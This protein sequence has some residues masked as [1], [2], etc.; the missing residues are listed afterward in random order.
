MKKEALI[1]CL[2]FLIVLSCPAYSLTVLSG[3]DTDGCY[4]IRVEGI[5]ITYD[6]SIFSDLY[7]SRN[8]GESWQL[9]FRDDKKIVDWLKSGGVRGLFSIDIPAGHYN[10]VRTRSHRI[11]KANLE[12]RIGRPKREVEFDLGEEIDFTTEYIDM[13]LEKGSLLGLRLD[14]PLVYLDLYVKWDTKTNAYSDPQIID[15]VFK[16]DING[17]SF[18]IEQVTLEE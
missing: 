17:T 10:A 4:K 13:T 9:I 2:L 1:F 16:K 18:K 3:P 14:N 12:N 15:Q 6:V 7:I 11:I 5:D 8:K